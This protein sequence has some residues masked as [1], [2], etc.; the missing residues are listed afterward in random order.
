MAT[1]S[2]IWP[3]L[4]KS[5]ND[6]SPNSRRPLIPPHTIATPY[7]SRPPPQWGP[8]SP[9]LFQATLF[10]G[11]LKRQFNR[12]NDTDSPIKPIIV[13]PSAFIVICYLDVGENLGHVPLPGADKEQTGGSKNHSI[14][15][16]KC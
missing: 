9:T 13:N 12:K 6:P 8:P 15:P 1:P 14:D 4:S 16:A 11:H 3:P 10:Q 7:I 5:Y 2:K